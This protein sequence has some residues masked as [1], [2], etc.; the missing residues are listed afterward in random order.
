MRGE[1]TGTRRN[2]PLQIV[3]FLLFRLKSSQVVDA[4]L[5]GKKEGIV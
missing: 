1:R 4:C 3:L 2:A 5:M